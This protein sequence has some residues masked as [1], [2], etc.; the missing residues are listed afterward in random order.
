MDVAELV[1]LQRQVVLREACRHTPRHDAVADLI[2]QK[3]FQTSPKDVQA[4][5]R[6]ACR[7][8]R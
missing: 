7:P 1:C 8:R 5:A 3:F 4:R 6:A 2:V